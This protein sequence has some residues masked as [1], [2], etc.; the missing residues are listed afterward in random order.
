MPIKKIFYFLISVL[1]IYTI[2]AILFL[3]LREETLGKGYERVCFEPGCIIQKGY[4]PIIYGDV[5]SY[6]FNEQYIYGKVSEPTDWMKEHIDDR[7][8]EQGFFIVDKNSGSKTVGLSTKE[9]EMKCTE[10]KINNCSLV[11]YSTLI[12]IY[13]YKYWHMLYQDE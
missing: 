2:L 13:D 9:F 3:W 8:D 7:G 5:R 11:H 12:L 1:F 6:A 4:W 10:L